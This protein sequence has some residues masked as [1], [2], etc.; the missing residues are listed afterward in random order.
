[1]GYF[2]SIT[3]NNG[4]EFMDDRNKQDLTLLVDSVSHIE[5]FAFLS[6]KNGD[7][8][9]FIVREWPQSFFFGNK[10]ITSILKRIDKDGMRDE[11]A[12]VAAVVVE[13]ISKNGDLYRAIEFREPSEPVPF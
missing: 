3:K 1:M 8:A 5:D 11:L 12:D 2:A 13:K 6:G 10:A 7:Y 4:I 9:V